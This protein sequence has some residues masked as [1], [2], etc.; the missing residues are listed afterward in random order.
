MRD[1]REE[2]EK[3]DRKQR[4]RDKPGMKKSTPSSHTDITM[5]AVFMCV[6]CVCVCVGGCVGV[7]VCVRERE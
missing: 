3:E 2:R 6:Y 5:L 4:E 1:E 7:W